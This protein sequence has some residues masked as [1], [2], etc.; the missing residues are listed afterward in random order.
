MADSEDLKFTKRAD[1]NI[2]V[3]VEIA[4]HSQSSEGRVL[5][6]HIVLVTITDANYA[7]VNPFHL[8]YALLCEETK[9]F[10]VD[11]FTPQES[12]ILLFVIRKQ[13]VDPVS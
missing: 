10:D 12:S 7:Q 13:K 6:L 3:A 11:H 5:D 9:A 1:D 2:S 8:T 4:L